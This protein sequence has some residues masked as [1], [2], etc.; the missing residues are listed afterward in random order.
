MMGFD[1]DVTF[2]AINSW[3]GCADATITIS[4][5]GAEFILAACAGLVMNS[6]DARKA[7]QASKI[8]LSIFIV[9]Q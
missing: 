6:T 2:G 3:F 8:N 9:H 5:A 1:S 4:V 7:G